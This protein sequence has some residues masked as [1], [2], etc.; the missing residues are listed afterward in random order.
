MAFV[1][2]GFDEYFL[3]CP[4]AKSLEKQIA[5]TYTKARAIYPLKKQAN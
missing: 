3:V 5:P 4:E 1:N 2:I